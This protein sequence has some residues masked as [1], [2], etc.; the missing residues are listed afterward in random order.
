M[1][2]SNKTDD[3]KKNP[4]DILEDVLKDVKNTAKGRQIKASDQAE[5]QAEDQK[6]AELAEFRKQKQAEDAARIK[7][8]LH[9]MKTIS[10]LPAEQARQAQEK[11]EKIDYQKKQLDQKGYEIRQLTHT[12]V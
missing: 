10:Q 11:A 2:N 6:K 12:K 7:L 5:K 4:L 8:Q 1:A 9:K 3:K